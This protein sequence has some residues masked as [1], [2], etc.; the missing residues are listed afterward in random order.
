MSVAFGI[1]AT[2]GQLDQ[3]AAVDALSHAVKLINSESKSSY[4]TD[5]PCHS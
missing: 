5:R 4:D 1:V 3:T 2:L